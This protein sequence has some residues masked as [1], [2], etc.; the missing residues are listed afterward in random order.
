MPRLASG[1][2][3]LQRK[4]LKMTI[5]VLDNGWIS[6]SF[7]IGESPPYNDAI[8]MPPDQYNALT[9]DQIEA[10]KQERYDSWVAMVKEA[11]EEIIDGE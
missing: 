1:G 3:W 8:V 4:G 11:S 7:T 10:M 9:F 5:T 6:D 2:A